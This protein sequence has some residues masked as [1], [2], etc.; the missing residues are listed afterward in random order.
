MSLSDFLDITKIYIYPTF[1]SG[2]RVD[3]GYLDLNVRS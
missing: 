3:F 1:D 2:I